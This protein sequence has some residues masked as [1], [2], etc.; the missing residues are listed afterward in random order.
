MNDKQISPIVYLILYSLGFLSMG[1]H[2]N[3]IGPLIPYLAKERNVPTTQYSFLFIG[4]SA[5]NIIGIILYKYLQSKGFPNFQHVVLL[6][7]CLGYAVFLIV[8]IEY[9]TLTTDCISMCVFGIV[10]YC[11]STTL[12]IC[13]LHISK[14][15]AGTWVSI[16][17]GAY[18]IGSLLAPQFVKWLET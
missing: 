10:N 3:S 14:N 9:D 18:G 2:S 17:H 5:G 12:N 11:M 16:S 4:I 1:L 6:F 8:F 7:C 15:K 13:I